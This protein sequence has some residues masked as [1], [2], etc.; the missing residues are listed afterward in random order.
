MQE[1]EDKLKIRISDAT[2]KI[3]Q[4]FLFLLLVAHW[5]GSINFMLVR[6]A[7][8]PEGSWAHYLELEDANVQRKYY[9]SVWKA[10]AMLLP[11]LEPTN[12]TWCD[13]IHGWCQ[14]EHGITLVEYYIGAIFASLLISNVSSI[15][16]SVNMA[17][18]AFE[19]KLSQVNEYMRAKHL[20]A[21]IRDSVREFY[22]LRF[23]EGKL[24]DEDHILKELT[25]QLRSQIL[26]FNTREVIKTVPVLNSGPE[27]LGRGLAPNLEAV[28]AFDGEIIIQED[29]IATD[30][31]FV[32]NGL[33]EIYSKH[34]SEGPV[35]I[36]GDGCY[37]GDVAVLLDT[38]EAPVKRTATVQAKGA[39]IVLYSIGKIS[40]LR[41]LADHPE[42]EAYMQNI[43]L[44]RLER[45]RQFNIDDA[46]FNPE[47]E[48]YED[49][50]DKKTELFK[51]APPIGEFK[52]A[53]RGSKLIIPRAKSFSPSNRGDT[54]P[55]SPLDR[56]KSFAAS[57]FSPRATPRTDGPAV[58]MADFP[59]PLSM[60]TESEYL[61]NG[62]SGTS[63]SKSS[64]RA[65]S[66][67]TQI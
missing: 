26:Q 22:K 34:F 15:L 59:K 8:F 66:V 28:V 45:I 55:P 61:Q 11:L 64:S 6:L 43:A 53:P 5:M 40:L 37:V 51:N 17:G 67:E 56:A 18:R 13:G 46:D 14:I 63:R 33:L 32:Y 38:E 19:E 23:A 4:L 31:Y 9:W 30:V 20:S 3:Y 1:V 2:L 36:V 52:T 50:E 44:G 16:L 58:E 24:F 57:A 60:E 54:S 48:P 35:N 25:P 7:G 65:L 42:I 47:F 39:H 21:D 41:V 29:T 62:G 49:I 27:S 10:L 12:L